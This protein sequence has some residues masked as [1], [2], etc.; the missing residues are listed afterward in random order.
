[1]INA[2]LLITIDWKITCLVELSYGI[3]DWG[4]AIQIELL[5]HCQFRILQLLFYVRVLFI[6]LV[7]LFFIF[8]F[9][10]IF[11]EWIIYL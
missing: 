10:Y 1:M 6:W 7:N 2:M 4:L 8:C 3:R 11:I 9:P 5:K